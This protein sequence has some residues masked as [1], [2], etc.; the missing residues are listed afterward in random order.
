MPIFVNFPRHS[1]PNLLPKSEEHVGL[2]KKTLLDYHTD[3]GLQSWA[4]S[5]ATSA[6][7]Q[8]L[9]DAP[10]QPKAP[11]FPWEK[12]PPNFDPPLYHIENVTAGISSSCQRHFIKWLVIQ[13]TW[14]L[15][16]F[17][18]HL[19]SQMLPDSYSA[20]LSTNNVLYLD[21]LVTGQRFI[22]RNIDV[23]WF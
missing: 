11:L 13:K 4:T 19:S 12:T 18:K 22:S 14:L 10:E 2:S 1:S 7:N 15:K 21:H 8:L 20:A 16:I 6:C 3:E 5:A 9:C 23:Y 17:L